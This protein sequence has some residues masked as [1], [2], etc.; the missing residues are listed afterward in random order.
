M[1]LCLQYSKEEEARFL[2]HLDLMTAMERSFRR[3][4]LPLAFS[5]GFNPHPRVSYASALAVG[6]T[7][8][9]EYLDVQFREELA[10]EEVLVRLNKAL[11]RGLRVKRAVPVSR[12]KE[13]LMALIN[14]ACYRVKV[15]F[16]GWADG[17]TGVRETIEKAMSVPAYLVQR[18][19]K[20]GVRQVDI[21]PGILE[22]AGSLKEENGE[23][24]LV[25]EMA[26]RTGSSGNVKP[27]E[28]VEML[29]ALGSWRLG[30]NLRIHRLGLYIYA[31]G[32]KWSPLERT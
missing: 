7:S 23:K 25:L 32:K 22:L 21:R 13:S 8:E 18:Q 4:A 14:L 19:G 20:K 3:A 28:V 27:E 12:R 26:V 31:E 15:P 5:E 24:K 16:Y 9:A 1:L 29:K 2:S 10:P 6:V 17:N 30:N 11:P